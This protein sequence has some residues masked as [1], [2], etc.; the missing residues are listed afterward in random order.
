MFIL[1]IGLLSR[2]A[3][4]P[5]E[6]FLNMLGQQ[7]ACALVYAGAFSI[8]I[9]ICFVLIPYLGA[10]GAAIATATA[11]VIETISLFMIARTGSDSTSSSGAAPPSAE[12]RTCTARSS[13]S[14]R[15]EWR[16]ARSSSRRS[17]NNGARLPPSALE[18]NVFYEPAFAFAAAPVF[19]PDVGAVL[20]WSRARHRSS[21]DFSGAGRA[22]P[23]GLAVAGAGG[24]DACLCAARRPA[25][26]PRGRCTT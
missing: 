24:M 9:V 22:R 20:V 13:S 19:G 25:G 23:L 6:R 14:F 4:G 8:N 18:P 3:I 26:R 15:V 12:T 16:A 1:A 17:P 10:E 5:M 2:A 7:R 11:L 21:W